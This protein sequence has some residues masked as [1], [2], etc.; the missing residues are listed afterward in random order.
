MR[1]HRPNPEFSVD[2][3]KNLCCF[4]K[5]SLLPVRFQVWRHKTEQNDNNTRV[6]SLLFAAGKRHWGSG[7]VQNLR[8]PAE[9]PERVAG[10]VVLGCQVSSLQKIQQ[11]VG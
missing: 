7:L 1:V 2:K 3:R 10:V 4:E 9:G 11:S 8:R 5:V 6:E